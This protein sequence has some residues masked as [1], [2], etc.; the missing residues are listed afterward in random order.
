[1]GEVPTEFNSFLNFE[2]ILY[3]YE[4]KEYFKKKFIFK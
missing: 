2:R 4:I 3:W 1:M